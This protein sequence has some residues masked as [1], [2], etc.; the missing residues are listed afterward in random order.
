MLTGGPKHI[1]CQEDDDFMAALDKMMQ[2]TYQVNNLTHTHTFTPKHKYTHTLTH[3]NTQ[4][5]M[6]SHIQIHTNTHMQIHTCTHT[7][8]HTSYCI[9]YALEVSD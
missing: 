8:T 3:T 5:H 1:K 7:N 4:L 6:H 2:E 9:C